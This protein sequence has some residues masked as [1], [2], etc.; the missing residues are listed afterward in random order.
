[1][2]SREQKP[3]L[4][5]ENH[6]ALRM[7]GA[8]D[9]FKVRMRENRLQPVHD[10][11]RIRLSRGIAPVNNPLSAKMPGVPFRIRHVVLMRQ[12]D[13]GNAA[14]R[15]KPPR[16]IRQIAGAVHQP[17]PI[18]VTDEITVST[19]ALGRV[20][21]AEVNRRLHQQ[22]KI[23]P[24]RLEVHG[25]RGS[26]S[27]DR[28]G[29]QGMQ[30]LA[31]L[32]LID[33]LTMHSRMLARIPEHFRDELIAGAAIDA[34]LVYENRSFGIFGHTLAYIGHRAAFIKLLDIFFCMDIM[35]QSSGGEG[36]LIFNDNPF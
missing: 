8:G 21:A 26:N 28:A 10:H 2:I 34:A 22:W 13:A 11:F 36:E 4:K 20:K 19:K 9:Y 27:A 25:V 6:V 1:M 14:H 7:A 23:L 33:G 29:Q 15:F 31:L 30:G 32:L 17:V 12:K 16:Q 3:L 35:A 5:Q 24:R 18:G